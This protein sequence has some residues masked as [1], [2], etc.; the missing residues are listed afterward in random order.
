VTDQRRPTFTAEEIRQIVSRATPQ[1]AVL[2]T[3]LAATGLRINEALGLKVGDFYDGTLTIDRAIWKGKETTLKTRF[4]YRKVD[5][6][7]E[8]TQMLAA[9][10]GDR[11]EGY[12]FRARNGSP[13]GDRNV[14]RDSLHPILEDMKLEKRGF[15]A[16]RRFRVTW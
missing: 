5:L 12:F 2:Y 3:L 10:I 6:A 14:L 7:L 4:A 16:F 8:V 1:C 13:F 9:F 15:H 11:S